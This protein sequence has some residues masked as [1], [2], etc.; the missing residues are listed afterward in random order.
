[1]V[2]RNILV[3]CLYA[4]KSGPNTGPTAQGSQTPK[5]HT[6]EPQP[7]EFAPASLPTPGENGK[8]PKV[9]WFGT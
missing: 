8:H 3:F 4:V 9:K 1:M 2:M 5:Q 7:D 6:V